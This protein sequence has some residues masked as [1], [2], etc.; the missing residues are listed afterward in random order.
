MSTPTEQL[1]REVFYA[2][3]D[4]APS[5][6]NL[7]SGAVRKTK[8]RR[9]TL[10]LVAGAT[11]V[12]V[13][14]AAGITVAEWPNPAS[15]Q[16]PVAAPKPSAITSAPSGVGALPD[17]T[18]A[19][20]AFSYS[21]QIVADRAFAFDGTVSSIGAARTNRAGVELPLV[22][23]TFHVNR[24]FK[25]GTADTV[26]VDM[27]EP[28][29]SNRQYPQE[30]TVAT[31]GVGTRLL[32]SGEPRWGGMPLQDAIAWACGFTRYYDPR[33]ASDWADAVAKP[34]RSTATAR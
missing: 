32:V 29:Q 33:T 3:A 28:T 25:G 20:C 2:D 15:T 27:Y 34:V 5:P 7:A 19:S 12:V 17:A 23:V 13:G 21:P 31:Y 11:S 9:R 10:T 18:A 22:A 16:A 14:L 4:Q 26:T 30:V 24:W 1:L 8:Q 6:H